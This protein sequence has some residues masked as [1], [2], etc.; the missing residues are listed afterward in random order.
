MYI[1]NEFD[2]DHAIIHNDKE[3]ETREGEEALLHG[4]ISSMPRE[5]RKRKVVHTRP[6]GCIY[7]Y[8]SR[9]VRFNHTAHSAL[10]SATTTESGL[11]LHN[12]LSSGV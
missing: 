10:T 6:S 3:E 9:R 8:V 4:R 7:P 11:G 2:R 1:R 5:G 12:G